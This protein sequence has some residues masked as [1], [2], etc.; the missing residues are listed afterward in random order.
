MAGSFPVGRLTSFRG[1]N[2][3]GLAESFAKP[4]FLTPIEPARRLEADSEIGENWNADSAVSRNRRTRVKSLGSA[5]F[6]LE[7]LL[8]E[9]VLQFRRLL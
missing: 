6:R 8:A 9:V 1:G 5:L 2:D 4:L 3:L 7:S